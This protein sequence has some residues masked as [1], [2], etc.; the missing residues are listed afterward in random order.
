LLETFWIDTFWGEL[1]RRR[2]SL[3]I[4]PKVQEIIK[5]LTRIPPGKV[6][7]VKELDNAWR[8]SWKHKNHTGGTITCTDD[9][10]ARRV[11]FW[12]G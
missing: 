11:L 5:Y 1:L 10:Q 8:I 6:F 7:S 4:I 3:S 2:S 12:Q 9:A